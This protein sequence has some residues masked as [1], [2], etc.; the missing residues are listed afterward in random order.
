M[1]PKVQMAGEAVLDVYREHAEKQAKKTTIATRDVSEIVVIGERQTRGNVLHLVGSIERL[2]LLHPLVINTRNEL[3]AGRR[4]LAAVKELGWDKVPVTVVAS[5]DDALL[6]LTA[7][8]DENTCRA[9]LSMAERIELGE[10]LEAMEKPKAKARQR[11]GGGGTGCG[12]LPQ[13]EPKTRDKVAAALGVSGKTY[14]KAKKAKAIID[15]DPEGNADLAEKMD[16]PGAKVDPVYREAVRRSKP[17]PSA[18]PASR[19]TR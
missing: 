4:R 17:E 5:L 14:E 13:P 11:A 10:R 3:V 18:T 15:A 9:P 8:R 12:K 1:K 19:S 7:E 16:E 6:A 2:G